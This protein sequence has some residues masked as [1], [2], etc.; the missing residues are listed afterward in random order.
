M[1]KY[2][3]LTWFVFLV[4]F[5]AKAQNDTVLFSAKGGFYE[6][7][8][9]LELFNYYPQ[10][11]IRYTTNG[12][13]PT[14]KSQL[15]EEPLLLD[16][17]KYSKSDIYTI[18]D[19]PEN[20]FYLP[21]SVGHCIV[22]R[23]A[24]FNENDSC[25]SGVKTNSY[26]IR[27]LGCDTHGLP[28]ISLCADSLDLFDYERG[29][30]VPGVHY[31]W[32]SPL[33]SGNYFQRGSEWE[34]LCNVEYYDQDNA[35]INQQAGL[36][37]HGGST[38]RLQQ[39]NLKILAKEQ[40][41]KKRFKHHFFQEIPIESFKHLVLKPF[42]CS[43]GVK[44]GIQDA[45]AQKAARNLCIDV[46]A[47][48]MT[49]L[50]ING[51]YWGIYALQETP[52]ERYLDDHYD[53]DPDESNI[54]K[55]W[56]EF[57]H[58]D[59]T[60]WINLYQWVQETDFSLDENY[61]LMKERI[62]M[63]NFIDYWI[64]EMYSSNFDWPVQNTRCWQSGNGKWR[65]IFYDG[66]ACF[67]RVWDVFANAVDTSHS[68]HP[69]NAESTLFFRKLIDNPSFLNRFNERFM[70]L[71]SDQLQ[72]SSIIPYYDTLRETIKSEIPNQCKRF[73]FPTDVAQWEHDM[74]HVEYFLLSLNQRIQT[75]LHE[76]YEQHYD[77]MEERL[78]SFQCYPNPFSDEI[79]LCF[80]ASAFGA[81][82]IDIYDVLGRKVYGQACLFSHGINE[83]TL[84]PH[85]PAGVYVL[86]MGSLTQRIVRY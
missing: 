17:S 76:F 81:N 84:R 19:C 44:T 52:D 53:I 80:E 78:V 6:E 61:A 73:G 25:I 16:T 3:W 70:E 69:S 35:G 26:F 40:Y 57:E 33:Y 63:D 27:S 62:D 41:G 49:V 51:E 47:S 66:D 39:K 7:V 8:L 4:S 29:I 68:I 59:S 82:E 18:V 1:T 85:L 71:M 56:K 74:N 31:E 5:S 54:V 86:K 46:L 75:G 34:R 13:R 36:R 24:V 30:F 23:A 15:Y 12:T 50:F 14:A 65:W 21:D 55:N 28:A 48:R 9:Q 32:W 42:C 60:N 20:E 77:G 22:I 83:M 72:Y 43:N 38:R 2:I 37:T 58:G 45:M 79:H 67:S 10:N 64:F 11:H